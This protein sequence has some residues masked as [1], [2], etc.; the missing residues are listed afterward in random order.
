[1]GFSMK[2]HKSWKNRQYI[3]TFQAGHG[4]SFGSLAGCNRRSPVEDE[5][6]TSTQAITGLFIYV[7]CVFDNFAHFSK[8]TGSGRVELGCPRM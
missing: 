3:F 6:P 4:A 7:S 8:C 1:M 5:L 2:I